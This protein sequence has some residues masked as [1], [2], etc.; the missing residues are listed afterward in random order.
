MGSF[1]Q[2]GVSVGLNARLLEAVRE[3]RPLKPLVDEQRETGAPAD[4]PRDGL[5]RDGSAF[6]TTWSAAFE[7]GDWLT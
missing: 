4:E 6:E 7:I 1:D 2:I 5:F 3:R